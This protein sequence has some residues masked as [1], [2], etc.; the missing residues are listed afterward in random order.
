MWGIGTKFQ[1]GDKATP[2]VYKD[3][4]YVR[5]ISP[6]GITTDMADATVLASEDGF[7]EKQPTI[8]RLGEGTLTLL[9][10]PD[11]TDQ[12]AFLAKQIAREKLNCRILFPNDD[13]CFDFTAYISGF[14]LGEITPEGLLEATVTLAASAKPVF[15]KSS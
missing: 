15:G 14:E 4:A 8:H 5:S 11:D 1:I 12:Q 3:I 10:E 6:P 9:F 2:E 7:E 13:D